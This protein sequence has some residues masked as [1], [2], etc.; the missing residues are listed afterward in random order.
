MARCPAHCWSCYLGYWPRPSSRDRPIVAIRVRQTQEPRPLGYD[1]RW[2]AN[3]R[4]GVRPVRW[5]SITLFSRNRAT[6]ALSPSER[7]R[8]CGQLDF[9]LRRSHDHP[10]RNGELWLENLRVSARQTET[11][12]RKGEAN[13]PLSHSISAIFNAT[14]VP[15][16]YFFLVETKKC[17]LDRARR[18][19]RFWWASG[20]EGGYHAARS[21]GGRVEADP[22]T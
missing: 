14:S 7:H 1:R 21:I 2:P 17:S 13:K 22:G 16:I 18:H 4:R 10:A 19:I 12:K 6:E 11:I 8:Q 3:H 20:G 9:L 15:I 5:R